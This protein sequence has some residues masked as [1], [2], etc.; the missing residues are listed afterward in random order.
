MLYAVSLLILARS[1]F[2][3]FEFVM[4]DYGYPLEHE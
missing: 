2:R 4:G 1:V 3:V